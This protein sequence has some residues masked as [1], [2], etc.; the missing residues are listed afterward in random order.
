MV[1]HLTLNY[2]VRSR[3]TNRPICKIWKE[4]EKSFTSYLFA[5]FLDWKVEQ[6]FRF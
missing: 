1:L 5:F 3:L 2:R 6:G 4:T